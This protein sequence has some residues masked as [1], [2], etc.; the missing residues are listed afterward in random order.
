MK[1]ILLIEDR[2]KRQR[3]FRQ[4]TDIKFEDYNDILDNC[5][6]DKYNAFLSEM[7]IGSFDLS[8]YDIIISHKSAFADANELILKK[9]TDHC[10]KHSK[11]L[12]LFSGG[13]VGNYYTSDEYEVLELNSK[14]FYSQNLALYLE[15][16]KTDNDNLLMLAYGKQWELNII[17]KVIESINLYIDTKDVTLRKYIDVPSLE[18]INIISR[19]IDLNDEMEKIID[20][21]DYL[22]DIVKGLADE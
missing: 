8:S 10:K 22:L 20:F 12:V 17:L 15:T 5:I 4:Q 21:R 7:L 18:S 16:I 6:E 14:T 19:T 9:L 1:K 11:S 2:H 13:I 3:L